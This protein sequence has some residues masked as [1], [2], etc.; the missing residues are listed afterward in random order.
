[1]SVDFPITLLV[2]D[3]DPSVRALSLET[4]AGLGFRVNEAT[5]GASALALLS[6]RSPDIVLTNLNLPDMTGVELL[7]TIKILLPRTEIA[8]L[9]SRGTVDSAVQAIRLGAYHYLTKPLHSEELHLMLQ[10]IE[11][12]IRLAREN[13]YLRDWVRNDQELSEIAGS[14]PKIHEILRMI[15]RLKD[16]RAP[17]FIRGEK[18]TGKELVARAI[19][20]RGAL[21]KRPFVAVDCGSLDPKM[22]GAEL[23]GRARGRTLHV[24]VATKSGRF[25][26]AHGGT[27]FLANVDKLSLDTQGKLLRVIQGR[28]ANPAGGRD[29][30]RTDVRVI[31]AADG[32]FEKALVEKRF[33]KELY[34]CL[35]VM[36]IQMPAL[37][38]RVGDIPALVHSLI[39]R[40]A[41]NRQIRVT[42]EA[43]N[44]LAAYLWPGNI[45]ELEACIEHALVHGN[46]EIIDWLDLALEVRANFDPQAARSDRA[47]NEQRE[48]EGC[49]AIADAPGRLQ[50]PTTARWGV[51]LEDAERATIEL[52]IQQSGGDKKAASELLGISRKT[53]YRKLKSYGVAL[54]RK[55][56]TDNATS[57]P[58]LKQLPPPNIPVENSPVTIRGQRTGRAG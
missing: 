17:V 36:T 8:I 14:S 10:R 20:Y 18:G 27:I 21:A 46:P 3:Q 5:N 29:R 54:Q 56:E 49:L 11:E 9:T 52:A 58:L 1:M 22:A 19:H 15:A 39:Q 42:N 57:F 12:K 24:V 30:L 40:R 45:S 37:R 26:E 34:F 32:D 2:V 47:G 6:S 55:R 31:A 23:F 35:N 4:G 50:P 44:C 13:E 33:R 7:R 38:E 51:R 28:D 48:A 43:M 41:P 53:L 25:Q 16:T